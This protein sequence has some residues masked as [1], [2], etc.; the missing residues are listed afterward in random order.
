MHKTP[1]KP[2]RENWLLIL[3]ALLNFTHIVDFMIMMPLGPSFMRI[4]NLNPQQFGW[5]VSVYAISAGAA[6]VLSAL[7]V[8]RFD[9]KRSL[10]FF[11]TGFTIATLLC[12]MSEGY[13][14]LMMARALTGVFGGVLI[15]IVMSIVSDVVPYERRAQAM[16]IV[17]TGFSLASIFGVPFGLY[18]AHVFDWHTPFLVLGLFSAVLLGAVVKLV[19]SVRGHIHGRGANPFSVVTSTLRDPA[20]ITA[21]IFMACLVL[22][23]FTVIPFISPSLVR[24]AGMTEAQLPLIYL[25]GG[26]F[27]IVASPLVGRFADK[28]GKHK[29][30]VWGAM[31]SLIPIFL[32]TNMGPA[33]T[34]F[35]LMA[36]STFFITMSGRMVPA[37]AMV[38]AS[39]KAEG[40]GG[41]MS[42]VSAVQ[43]FAAAAS[44]ALAG[45]VIVETPGAGRLE[46]YQYIGYISATFTIIAIVINSKLVNKEGIKN[47]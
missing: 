31:L 22:G 41:F 17:S 5:L 35:I 7:Y 12:A 2:L 42:F 29:I 11:Y 21:L 30:F 14:Q 1:Q 27:S 46:N 9:R 24:N 43:Q 45:W 4:F 40:R 23:Q 19:P 28:Y 10:V 6:G 15:S 47:V 25:F 20:R 37:M 26:I 8:D 18:M 16:G 33:P 44:A 39:T 38:S 32:I 36:T 13:W 3:F 34:Y